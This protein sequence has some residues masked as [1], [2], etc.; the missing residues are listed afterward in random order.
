MESIKNAII[1]VVNFFIGLFMAWSA[2]CGGIILAERYFNINEYIGFI[3][4]II[5]FC[6]IVYILAKKLEKLEKD[7]KERERK[8]V[9]FCKALQN[10]NYENCTRI[11]EIKIIEAPYKDN[12]FELHTKDNLQIQL[13]L[14]VINISSIKELDNLIIGKSSHEIFVEI[15]SKYSNK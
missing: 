13:P 4:S 1:E 11:K 7:L 15:I 12:I 5:F 10:Y 6:R 8:I 14:S 3:I 2:I 9:Y